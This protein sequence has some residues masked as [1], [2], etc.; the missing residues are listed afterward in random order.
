MSK[1]T[2]GFDQAASSLACRSLDGAVPGWY[3]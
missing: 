2:P 1:L 3:R